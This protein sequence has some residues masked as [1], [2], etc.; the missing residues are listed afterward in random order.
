MR[1]SRARQLNL[2]R[3]V[4]RK[5]ILT[6]GY[7]SLRSVGAGIDRMVSSTFVP[8]C[9]QRMVTSLCEEGYLHLSNKRYRLAE[10]KKGVLE[11]LASPKNKDATF[12]LMTYLESN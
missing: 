10:D 3:E 8:P 6:E 4:L 5:I 2:L 9:V 12:H 7:F 11:L 1:H